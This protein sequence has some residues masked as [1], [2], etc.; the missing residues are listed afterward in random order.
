MKKHQH[1]ALL[2]AMLLMLSPIA[3][4]GCGDFQAVCKHFKN[5]K[6]IRASNCKITA[7][8]NYAGGLQ[9][10]KWKGPQVNIDDNEQGEFLNGKPAFS[11]EKGQ[12]SCYGLQSDKT[13]LFCSEY[14]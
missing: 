1:A 9:R 12:M 11:I 10:W 5:D 2:G 4:A 8:G 3:G 7:C 13:E 6:L 14:K